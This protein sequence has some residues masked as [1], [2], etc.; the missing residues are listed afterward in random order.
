M[1]HSPVE[2]PAAR[3]LGSRPRLG[4]HSSEDTSTDSTYLGDSD[5]LY[6]RKRRIAAILAAAVVVAIP[7]LLAA[8]I[9]L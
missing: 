8:L 9:M 5:H 2:L 7:V 1:T 4:G 3:H 6:R